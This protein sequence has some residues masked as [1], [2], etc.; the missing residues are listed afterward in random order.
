M[1]PYERGYQD[2]LNGERGPRQVPRGDASWSEKLYYRGW[3]DALAALK[4][5]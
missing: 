2:R 3:M 5:K 1:S 4:S